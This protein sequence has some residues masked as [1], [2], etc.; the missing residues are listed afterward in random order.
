MLKKRTQKSGFRFK[1]TLKKKIKEMVP[2]EYIEYVKKLLEKVLRLLKNKKQL[3]EE[4]CNKLKFYN[5][6]QQDNA[7]Y[8]NLKD[9]VCH[10][11]DNYEI[12]LQE[13]K[14][15]PKK[16]LVCPTGKYQ[17]KYRGIVY[18]SDYKPKISELSS[19][20]T[21]LGTLFFGPQLVLPVKYSYETIK[22]VYYSL[23]GN[24]IKVLIERYLKINFKGFVLGIVSN[25]ITLTNINLFMDKSKIL[26]LN[27]KS[28]ISR[29]SFKR[30]IIY[31]TYQED[32]F[33]YFINLK[34]IFK[35]VVT[36]K[37]NEE[38]KLSILFGRILG[39]LGAQEEYIFR[40]FL[41]ELLNTKIK[42]PTEKLLKKIFNK[43][44][45][46]DQ[47]INGIYL[48]LETFLSGC[49]FGLGHLTNLAVMPK[50]QVFKQVFLTT[51]MGFFL[52]IIKSINPNIYLVW[53]VHY[54]HNFLSSTV[55]FKDNV[56]V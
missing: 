2:I 22:D 32:I 37:T 15:N 55:L 25:L 49:L 6:Y 29:I 35:K 26:D 3:L 47:K 52:N 34:T 36:G 24:K 39:N 13:S 28:D 10:H 20:Y 8:F 31:S 43:S 23:S 17:R 48:I 40:E 14:K 54:Y 50:E 42:I 1:S 38:E 21:F 7:C 18:C 30:K 46:I 19:Y 16:T 53:L 41:I 56:S 45:S 12:Q 51:F 5:C 9:K 27:K 4:D 44:N 33:N 11:D